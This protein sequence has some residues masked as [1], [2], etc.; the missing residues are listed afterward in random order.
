MIAWNT[1]RVAKPAALTPLEWL[2]TRNAHPDAMIG[3][4]LSRGFEPRQP[5]AAGTYARHLFTAG[6]VKLP[7]SRDFSQA[8][9]LRHLGFDRLSR[10]KTWRRLSAC[11]AQNRVGALA[12]TL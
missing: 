1:W 8:Q 4:R 11:R 10:P 5:R 2:K 7:R 3:Y 12:A 6:A 9:R